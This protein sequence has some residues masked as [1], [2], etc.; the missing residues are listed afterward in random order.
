MAENKRHGSH[1][2]GQRQFTCSTSSLELSLQLRLNSLREA[3]DGDGPLLVV[4]RSDIAR[5]RNHILRRHSPNLSPHADISLL[6][7]S[8]RR[9]GSKLPTSVWLGDRGLPR[10]REAAARS[11]SGTDIG[12]GA[13]ITREPVLIAL[14]GDVTMSGE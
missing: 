4:R 10:K 14:S 12:I 6:S 3:G 11:Q 1:T 7:E 9:I 8:V 13:T 2:L 5:F